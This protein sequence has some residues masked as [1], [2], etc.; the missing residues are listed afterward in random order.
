MH[1]PIRILSGIST[2]LALAAHYAK[3]HLRDIPL[4]LFGVFMKYFWG[5]AMVCLLGF[6][7]YFHAKGF[8]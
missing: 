6:L 2:L 4:F 5:F 7:F 1:F 8:L 3:K